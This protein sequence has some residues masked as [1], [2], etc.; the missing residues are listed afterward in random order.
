MA[1]N[2]I[3]EEDRWQM[4][5]REIVKVTKEYSIKTELAFLPNGTEKITIEAW[6]KTE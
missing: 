5:I 6:H 4:F 1:L 2:E 3:N